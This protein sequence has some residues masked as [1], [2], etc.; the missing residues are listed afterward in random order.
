MFLMGEL[1][2]ELA[3]ARWMQ[4]DD[5]PANLCNWGRCG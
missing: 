4:L 5:Q 1:C 3:A 2:A